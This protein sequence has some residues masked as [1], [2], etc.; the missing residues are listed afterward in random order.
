MG[1]TENYANSFLC[2]CVRP[3]RVGVVGCWV[4]GCGKVWGLGVGVFALFVA[5]LLQGSILFFARGPTNQHPI[6]Q[7]SILKYDSI[8]R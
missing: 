6:L 1:L 2:I 8:V 4:S 5:T 3:P 7:K